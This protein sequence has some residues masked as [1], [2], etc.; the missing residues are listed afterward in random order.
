MSLDLQCV[1]P[2]EAIQLNNVRQLG[3][4]APGTTRILDITGADFRAVDEVLLNANIPATDVVIVSKNRLLA[5]VPVELGNTRISTVAVL[6]RRLTVTSKSLIRFRIGKTPGRVRG[7]LRLMQLFLKLLFTTP[8]KDI[9]N[10]KFGGGAL[11]IIGSTFGMQESGNIVSNFIIAVDTTARQ[12]VGIQGRD[13][14][15]PRDERLLSARVTNAGF[16]K[17]EGALLATIEIASQAGH[18]ALANLE[19]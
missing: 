19:L 18:A 4:G 9:F 12:L 7:T 8:G 16:D 10:P 14:R 5:Q 2:Q 17:T 11:R 3:T 15:L 1:F 13:P 6:S